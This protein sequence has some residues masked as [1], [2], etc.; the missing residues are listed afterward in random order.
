VVLLAVLDVASVPPL[1]GAQRR[2]NLGRMS[3]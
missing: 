1:R 2:S 3:I